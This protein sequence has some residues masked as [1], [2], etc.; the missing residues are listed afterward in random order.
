MHPRRLAEKYGIEEDIARQIA[1]YVRRL[2]RD[3]GYV[4]PSSED[5]E[6][7]NPIDQAR[8]EVVE[9]EDEMPTTLRRSSSRS[10]V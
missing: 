5:K 9:P 1:N 7:Y 4:S 2:S 6:E 8:A 10:T 3:P